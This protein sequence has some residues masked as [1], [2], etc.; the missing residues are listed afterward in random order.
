M[1][2]L[3]YQFNRDGHYWG[4]NG[5]WLVAA[6]V[7][8]DSD[9]LARSNFRCMQRALE[10]IDAKRSD[11]QESMVAIERASYWAVGWIDYLV[12]QPLTPVH[13]CAER[14]LERLASYPVLDDDDFSQEETDEDN[15][16]WRSC[17]RPSERI[18]WIRRNGSCEFHAWH[19][20]LACVRGQ[21]APR[22]SNGERVSQ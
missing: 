22:P 6:T 14:L 4:S 15:E 3:A 1:Q 17:F 9:A 13:E 10:A 8:R 2:T 18:A 5:T 20:M 7:H 16:V 19:D 12:V 11:D 21:Y